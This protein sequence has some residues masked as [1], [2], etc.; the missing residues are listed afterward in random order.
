MQQTLVKVKQETEADQ[1]KR[2]FVKIMIEISQIIPETP[3]L[4]NIAIFEP[5]IEHI[6]VATDN[7][8]EWLDDE[9]LIWPFVGLGRFYKGQGLYRE[10]S[11]YF[12]QCPNQ[13]EQRIG[14]AHST[15]AT[16]LNNL[17]VLYSDQEKYKEAE[18]LY[19]RSLAIS[20]NQLGS[21]LISTIWQHFMYFKGNTKKRN[22]FISDLYPSKRI[23]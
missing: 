22:L 18:L 2:A 20:E 21:A 12:E 19:Q 13:I 1:L 15:L 4:E 14:N 6:K 7:L 5:S 16:A 23:Y 9:D 11:P 8:I 3:T 10:A 17:A